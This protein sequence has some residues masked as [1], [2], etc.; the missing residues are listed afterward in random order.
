MKHHPAR[1]TSLLMASATLVACSDA[2]PKA[3]APHPQPAPV[4]DAAPQPGAAVDATLAATINRA[5]GL[6]GR[7]EFEAA[8]AT[9]AEAERS[10]AA[11]TAPEAVKRLI[12]RNRAIARMNQSLE[13][14]QE[15]AIELLAPLIA[16]DA[17]DVAARYCVG[18]CHLFLGQPELAEPEFAAVVA[19][20]ADD[21]YALYY[22]GQC[23]EFLDRD[24]EAFD[25]YRAAAAAD[26]TLRSP[27]LGMQRIESKRGND[28]ASSTYLRLFQELADNPQAR[29]AEFKYTRMGEL[30]LVGVTPSRTPRDEEM[31]TTLSTEVEQVVIDGT[32]PWAEASACSL[33][34]ADLNGDGVHDLFVANGRAGGGN[35]V[36]LGVRRESAV[37]Y[38]WVADHPLAEPRDVRAALWGDIDNDGDMDVYLCQAGRNGLHLNDGSGGFAPAPVNAGVDGGDIDTIDGTMA[39]LDHDGDLDLLLCNDSAPITLL[40]NNGDGTFRDISASSGAIGDARPAIAALVQDFDGDR[41]AD[42]LLMHREAPPQMLWNERQWSYRPAAS[43][44]FAELRQV[45]AQAGPLIGAL[46]GD[47]DA[48][49]IVTVVGVGRDGALWRGEPQG[50]GWKVDRLAAP[51]DALKGSS[52]AAV[53]DFG[54]GRGPSVVTVGER[55]LASHSLAQA[56][57]LSTTLPSTVTANAW[58][59]DEGGERGPRIIALAAPSGSEPRRLVSISP[60]AAAGQFVTLDIAGRTDPTLSMRSNASGIGTSYAARFG[61]RWVG[62][63]TFRS[64]TTRG[65][66]LRLPGI[67]VG[68]ATQLDFVNLEWSDGVFQSEIDL[69]AG[70]RHRITEAQRQISSCPVIFAWNGERHAFVTDCLGVGGIGYLVAP[71]EYAPPRPWE[72]VLLPEGLLSASRDNLFDI[73]LA[74]PMEEACY[75]DAA[76]LVMVELPAGWSMTVDERMGLAGPEVTG[77]PRFYRLSRTP[78]DVRDESGRDLTDI[79]RRADGQAI[80]QPDVDA[81]FI[82]YLKR[83]RTITLRFDEPLD[84]LPGAPTLIA[85]GWV[86][87]PYC[88]TNFAASQAG[89]TL[90]APDLEALGADGAWVRL[91]P[92]WGYPAGMPREMSLPLERLPKGTVALRLTS[93]QEIYWDAFSVAGV[94]HCAEAMRTELPLVQAE[95]AECGF[96]ERVTHGEKR[97][98]YRYQRRAPLWDAR[99]QDGFYTAFGRCEPLVATTDDAVAIIGPGEEIRLLFSAPTS[100]LP[101]RLSGGERRFILEVDGWCKDRDLFTRDGETLEPLPQRAEGERSRETSSLHRRFNTRYRDSG[102]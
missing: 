9:L 52:A 84:T 53:V 74:E 44:P 56:A 24:G 66:S 75:L 16:A 39:D 27:L 22:L 12:T 10:D 82:G 34:I 92:P 21:A 20:R 61:D 89:V 73:R 60:G 8:E 51:N 48:D 76:R 85:H 42:L 11:R 14:S 18:L 95:I 71:G 19:A 41:D 46:A 28:E 81:R 25:R 94:E 98:E 64:A 78:S 77:A 55:T 35:L 47:W 17:G 6:M 87:Y 50:A 29:L 26:P 97:P 2:P 80:P 65:Q 70:K 33:T 23:L 4:S 7:F 43:A 67:G 36:F 93:N 62:G 13:G 37:Q 40:S 69:A 79:V 96:Q 32:P 63:D 5:A 68:S 100:E 58:V 102:W 30:A 83:P 15:A 91:L 59:V 88:Q 38:R 86:E 99:A 45:G 31:P 90:D 1:F 101:R 72:R 3:P 54:G 49:G 57:G